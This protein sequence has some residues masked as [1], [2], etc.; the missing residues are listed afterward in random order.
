MLFKGSMMVLVVMVHQAVGNAG[1][2]GDIGHP[3][4]MKSLFLDDLQGGV[5]YQLFFFRPC[6]FVLFGHDVPLKQKL[7]DLSIKTP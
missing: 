7:I 4:L 5:E 1:L 2:S 6:G 3:G